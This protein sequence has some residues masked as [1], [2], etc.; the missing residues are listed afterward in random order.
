MSLNTLKTTSGYLLSLIRKYSPLAAQA[1]SKS[2]EDIY[3]YLPI[4][5]R[6]STSGQPSEAQFAL[7][8]EAGF[9]SVINLAPHDAENSLA[10]E[11]N[12]LSELGLR[13]T[14]IP[15]NFVRPSERKFEAF[16]KC[17]SESEGEK[18]WLHCAANMR[19]SAF[20]FRYRT[21]VLGEDLEGAGAD[22]QKIWTPLGVW[23]TFI[24]TPRA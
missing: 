14:H 3:N 12:T 17:M 16:V 19:A 4:S 6:L 5:D 9:D 22:L 2:L 21:Q 20:L 11:A 13:Y 7:I 18:V 10:D 8:K 1:K 24:N 23:K 15:V